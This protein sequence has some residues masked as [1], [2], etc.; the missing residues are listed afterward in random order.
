MTLAGITLEEFIN[1]IKQ[2]IKI[3]NMSEQDKVKVNT[4]TMSMAKKP[5]P[6][7]QD[8]NYPKLKAMELAMQLEP[9]NTNNLLRDTKTILEYLVT[10]SQTW[11]EK[12]EKEYEERFNRENENLY[13]A[14][15]DATNKTKKSIE[16][17]QQL[18]KDD[19]AS[20]YIKILKEVLPYL[21]DLR[22]TLQAKVYKTYYSSN[23]KR[24]ISLEEIESHIN[25]L[26]SE[27]Y[28]HKG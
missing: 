2:D 5:K 1:I 19:I 7:E 10:P 14:Y 21:Q 27:S 24:T 13:K 6:L 12:A 23:A 28:G 4:D 15:E 16:K 18:W 20:Y 9:G 25:K 26:V 17:E 3:H 8:I 22:S 11:L